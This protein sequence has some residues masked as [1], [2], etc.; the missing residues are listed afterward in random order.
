MNVIFNKK[1]NHL[2]AI[3]RVLIYLS[4]I[5][6]WIYFIYFFPNNGIDYE[7]YLNIIQ[8][9]EAGKRT[10]AEPGFIFFVKFL[11]L[12]SITPEN[13]VF[14]LRVMTILLLLR[15]FWHANYPLVGLLFCFLVPNI[16]FGTL[17][18]LQMW[19]AISIGIQNYSKD[20]KPLSRWA[21]IIIPLTIHFSA[22]IFLIIP[23][24]QFF[25]FMKNRTVFL[26]ISLCSI[27][28]ITEL[29]SKYLIS[30]TVYE[31]YLASANTSV[32][33]FVI[34]VIFIFIFLTSIKLS[35]DRKIQEISKH[36]ILFTFF[37]G[38]ISVSLSLDSEM[39][40]RYLNFCL[41]LFWVSITGLVNCFKGTQKFSLLTTFVVVLSFNS[42]VFLSNLEKYNIGNLN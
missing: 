23:I 41:P 37:A 11:L 1:Y 18:A 21:C 27:M 36:G 29:L 2:Y 28:P 42:L 12:L 15:F 8:R 33:P 24:F 4:A 5:L 31:K 14:L 16:A 10:F 9:I 17:N 34:L 30:F 25:S 40:L 22:I 6:S 38:I 20:L 7:S 39:T 3:T 13:I 19:L 32:K 35:K 26:V